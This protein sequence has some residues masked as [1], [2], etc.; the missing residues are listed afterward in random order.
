MTT[1]SARREMG[2]QEAARPRRGTAVALPGVL[3][4]EPHDLLLMGDDSRLARRRRAAVLHDPGDV[5]PE[6]AQVVDERSPGRVGSDDAAG[7]HLAAEGAQVV[8]H[9]GRAAEAA[10]LGRHLHDRNRCL[11]R[12]ALHRAPD[13]VIEHE[14]AGHEDT[15]AGEAADDGAAAVSDRRVMSRARCALCV[16]RCAFPT[17]PP[18]A[19]ANGQRTTNT[20]QRSLTRTIPAA[21]PSRPGPAPRAPSPSP[22]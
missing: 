2:E 20:G 10:A 17:P 7:R 6:A 5:G 3:A 18:A 13:E 12:D 15:D 1:T 19:Q 21:S 16:V 22:A 11:G 8:D 14:I 4:I 9:V